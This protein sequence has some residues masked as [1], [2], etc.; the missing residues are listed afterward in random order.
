M[1][2]TWSAL[3]ASSAATGEWTRTPSLI[4]TSDTMKSQ[5]LSAILSGFVWVTSSICT[6][7][8]SFVDLTTR[9]EFCSLISTSIRTELLKS[10]IRPGSCPLDPP[11]FLILLH[12]RL[13]QPLHTRAT[14][15]LIL[16]TVILLA[17]P[18]LRQSPAPLPPPRIQNVQTLILFPQYPRSKASQRGR[19]SLFKISFSSDDNLMMTM[20]GRRVFTTQR[21]FALRLINY[22]L[23]KTL[24]GLSFCSSYS[25]K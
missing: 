1:C 13:P 17:T 14:V 21:T 20:R 24:I 22:F 4:L 8:K 15:S 5:S 18:F 6:I 23:V 25:F 16:H 9:N 19:H 11:R 12:L 3:L 10:R 7:T 2:I